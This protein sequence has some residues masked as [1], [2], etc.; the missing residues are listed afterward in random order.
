M[1]RYRTQPMGYV[2][3]EFTSVINNYQRKKDILANIREY[4]KAPKDDDIVDMI[5][6]ASIMSAMILTGDYK[7]VLVVT[8]SNPTHSEGDHLIPAIHKFNYGVGKMSV[9]T[10]KRLENRFGG[11]YEDLDV[12]IVEVDSFYHLGQDK[13]RI[14]HDGEPFDAVVLLG[15]ESLTNSKH[16]LHE[17]KAVFS[18]HC[19]EVFDLIDIYRGSDRTLQGGILPRENVQLVSNIILNEDMSRQ[20]ET[21]KYQRVFH[22]IESIEQIYKVG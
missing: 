18:P 19:T 1:I 17:I 20:K 22:N 21:Y 5:T 16:K 12:D 9:T 8:S 15:N 14:N 10:P 11:L 2:D 3:G 7:N 4:L 6:D 13:V